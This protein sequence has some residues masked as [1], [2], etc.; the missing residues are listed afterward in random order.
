MIKKKLQRIYL[1]NQINKLI[2]I[3]Y[4][5]KPCPKEKKGFIYLIIKIIYDLE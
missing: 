2:I 4:G 5:R 3:I 1:N